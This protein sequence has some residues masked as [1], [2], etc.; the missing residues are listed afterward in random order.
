MAAARTLPEQQLVTE[1]HSFFDLSDSIKFQEAIPIGVRTS[2]TRM[3]AEGSRRRINTG[4]P[5]KVFAF[6]VS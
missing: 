3:A 6:R 5:S 1:K 4:P 2:L